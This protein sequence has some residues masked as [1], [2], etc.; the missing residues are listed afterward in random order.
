MTDQ[1]QH[2]SSRGDYRK[3]IQTECSVHDS[4]FAQEQM[5][6]IKKHSGE[7]YEMQNKEWRRQKYEGGHEWSW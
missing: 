3:C 4:W 7:A 1:C 5:S 2:C 6:L